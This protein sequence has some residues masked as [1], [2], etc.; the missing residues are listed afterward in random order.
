MKSLLTTIAVLFLIIQI[1]S[2]SSSQN[3]VNYS[4]KFISKS[5]KNS[6]TE[7]YTYQYGEN[8]TWS[9]IEIFVTNYPYNHQYIYFIDIG[10]DYSSYFWLK[11]N[12]NYYSSGPEWPKS[13]NTFI[14]YD[15]AGPKNLRYSM[16]STVYESV[17]NLNEAVLISLHI[18]LQYYGKDYTAL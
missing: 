7:V 5:E 10:T 8:D 3:S 11:Q 17:T 13:R 9:E 1:S 2:C 16:N 15:E 14:Y 12:N 6:H 4:Y 18:Y